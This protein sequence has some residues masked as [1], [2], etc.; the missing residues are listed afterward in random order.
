MEP[1]RSQRL[2]TVVSLLIEAPLREVMPPSIYQRIAPAAA[3]LRELGL[4]DRAIGVQFG[5]TDNTAAKAIRWF[6]ARC[7]GTS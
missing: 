5:V 6:Q 3:R 7:A 2:R 1:T 4:S